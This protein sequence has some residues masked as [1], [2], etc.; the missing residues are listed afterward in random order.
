MHC[1]QRESDNGLHPGTWLSC[2]SGKSITHFI[3]Y[4]GTIEV[5]PPWMVPIFRL[6][7]GLFI[8]FVARISFRKVFRMDLFAKP[9]EAGRIAS[10][11]GALEY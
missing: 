9:K 7:H 1:V 3:T 6:A 5:L 8:T 2:P 10:D 11:F 4:I